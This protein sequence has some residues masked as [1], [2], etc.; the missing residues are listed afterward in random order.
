MFRCG[1]PPVSPRFAMARLR[2]VRGSPYSDL[3]DFSPGY[4]LSPSAQARLRLLDWIA[5]HG[6]TQPGNFV[7]LGPLFG[8]ANE[9]GKEQALAGTL[10]A[11]EQVGLL[12][13]QKTMGWGGWSCDVL[14]DGID[15]IEQLQARRGDLRARRKAARD[16]LLGW[17]A[18]RTLHGEAHPVISAFSS[19]P[20]GTYYGD[21]FT[22]AEINAASAWLRDQGYIAGSAVSGG[23]IPRPSITTAGERVIESGRSVNDDRG[24]LDFNVGSPA[25][26]NRIERRSDPVSTNPD[27]PIFVVHGR[28]HAVLHLAVRV[29]QQTTGREVIVL[30]EQANAGRTI[31]E[32]FEDHAVSASY[33]VVL[34]T[35]DDEGGLP[36]GTT[37]SRGRQNVVFELGFFFG[38]LG[39]KRVA[40]LLGDDVEQPSDINGL[41]YIGLDGGGGWKHQLC[42]E[43][44]AAG[45]KVNYSRIP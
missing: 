9:H 26:I 29:L 34:L 23:G 10:D 33:A 42:R 17:L 18:E 45:I 37:R 4:N 32:K 36:G 13:L 41:V 21:Q 44:E 12:R 24:V 27:G 6:G 43:L 30:H 38:K 14:P 16:A 3:V 31:L 2:G 22:K 1:R 5:A 19:S 7:E 35:G 8:T 25:T 40:V 11:L 39:R 15:L 28:D 20:Y